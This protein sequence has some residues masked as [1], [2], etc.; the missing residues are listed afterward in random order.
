MATSAHITKIVVTIEEEG[1]V[2]VLATYENRK[3]STSG[4]LYPRHH[5][6]LVAISGACRDA[7][8][9]K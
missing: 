5:T 3:W 2:V 8:K 4:P 9:E 6:A 1:S 7:D